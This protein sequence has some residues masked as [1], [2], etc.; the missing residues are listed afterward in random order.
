MLPLL[1][2]ASADDILL[3][4]LH[5][6]AMSRLSGSWVGMKIVPDVAD[7][8]FSAR[9]LS[10]PVPIIEPDIKVP[11]T[12]LHNR[13]P[14]MPIEQEMRQLDYRLPAIAAYCDA[15]P[16]D[17]IRHRDGRSRIGIVAA[18]K[19]WNDLQEAL[20]LLGLA[21]GDLERLGI[22]LFKLA[23]VWPLQQAVQ[24][25]ASGLED[26]IVVEEKGP[27]V[28]DQLRAG[29]YGRTDAP[30][31][32][33]KTAGDG[34]VLFKA[35]GELYP[36][37]IARGLG[38]LLAERFPAEAFAVAMEKLPPTGVSLSL[39]SP[40]SAIRKPF[41]CSGCPHNRS[42]VVPEGSRALAGIGCG[43]CG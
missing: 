10:L 22:A 11:D 30:R 8:T 27:L 15:N 20:R 19:S 16:L 9:P 29:L 40:V 28:E 38:K 26:V 31:I 37:L 4:G 18:G 25:F 42:T 13:W 21:P 39:E 36:E 41:F 33:G 1:Y 43:S 5:G 23:M 17:E 34:S 14:E 3:F 6:F 12:G 35:T 2:P 24:D 32:F 7:A